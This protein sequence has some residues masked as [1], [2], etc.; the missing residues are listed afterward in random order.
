VFLGVVA[1]LVA[2]GLLPVA[3]GCR[4]DRDATP[5]DVLQELPRADIKPDEHPPDIVLAVDARV[6]GDVRRSLR[7][8]VPARVT[9]HMRVPPRAAL[10]SALAVAHPDDAPAE[11]GVLFQMGISDGRVYEPLFE[12]A[13]LVREASAWQ[14]L[15]VDLRRYGGWQWSLFYRPS[16]ITWDITFNAYAA[17]ATADDIAAL[18]ATPVI[19]RVP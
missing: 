14:P 16:A 8:R 3:A 18:W 2:I 7:M 13:I 4:S 15:R 1:G 11:A 10:T 17:G 12:R 19:A 5:V 6:G 9:I